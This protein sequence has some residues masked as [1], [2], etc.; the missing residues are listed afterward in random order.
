MVTKLNESK[1][2][3]DKSIYDL[4]NL[5]FYSIVTNDSKLEKQVKNELKQR[6]A[7]NISI[8]NNKS[9]NVYKNKGD[10]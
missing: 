9:K 2:F 7:Y 6:L 4:K 10:N 3:K 8:E 1:N 5:L